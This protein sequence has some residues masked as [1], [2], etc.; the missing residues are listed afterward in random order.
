MWRRLAATAVAL[1]WGGIILAGCGERPTE[2]LAAT[3]PLMDIG[4][5]VE[6]PTVE[7]GGPS[8]GY[9]NQAVQLWGSA[10]DEGG[11]TIEYEWG[12]VSSPS[13]SQWS[14]GSSY[15]PNTSFQADKA[16][17]Y[18][19]FLGACVASLDGPLCGSAQFTLTVRDPSTVVVEAGEDVNAYTGS[20][21]VELSGQ[22]FDE[23]N[24]TIAWWRW[25]VAS[26]PVGTF[27]FAPNNSVQDVTFTVENP[28]TYTVELVVCVY[29]PWLDEEVCSD[30]DYLSVFAVDNEAPTAVAN[31]Y[32]TSVMAGDQVCFDTE[33][34]SDPNDQPLQYQWGFGDGS[35]SSTEQSPC[36]VYTAGGVF[37]ATVTV[38]DPLGLSDEST[39]TITVTQAS[40]QAAIASLIDAVEGLGLSPDRQ[41]GLV[42]KLTFASASLDN[43]LDVDAC[44]QLTAFV[45]QVKGT[46]K[47][48]KLSQAAGQ[49]LIDAAEAIRTQIGCA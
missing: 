19:L 27:A 22:A 45:K 13:E 49:E 18:T 33:G 24:R 46:V 39:V 36:H 17:E 35:T 8:V 38:T 3:Q 37:T 40:P 44:K 30:P 16:G 10:Y 1:T 26:G 42:E 6:G 43:G 34:T 7:A 41:A 15:L 14:F 11:R 32:P 20:T 9:T 31:A 47:A 25:S 12:V 29:D 21:G 5:A 28:G 2:P 48:R 23:Q 4:I